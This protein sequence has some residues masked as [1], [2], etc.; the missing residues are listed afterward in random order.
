MR[1]QVKVAAKAGRNAINGWMGDVLKL[2]VTVAPEKGKANAAVVELLAGAL[3]LPKS[4]V[5]I[6]AGSASVW[7]QIEVDGLDR[8]VA[9]RRLGGIVPAA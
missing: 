8:A 4:A 2:S 5:K 1:L 3:D 6:V 9:M 7:K